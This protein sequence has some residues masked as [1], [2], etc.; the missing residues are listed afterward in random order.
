[1]A[2]GRQVVVAETPSA[3]ERHPIT[4]E[5]LRHA[6]GN[7]GL[8]MMF[9]MAAF[10]NPGHGV[11]LSHGV[12][13]TRISDAVWS[14]GLI[15]MGVF[16]VM[17]P[18]PVAAMLDWRAMLSGFGAFLLPTLMLRS[19]FS[20]SGMA[21]E[22]GVLLEFLGVVLS[23]A[24]RIC[25]GHTFAVL[26]ANRGIVTKGPFHFVRHPVYLGWIMLVIGFCATY[27][28]PWNVMMLVA[29]MGLTFW[30]IHLEEELLGTDPAYVEY[31]SKVP[32]RMIP[33]VY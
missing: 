10:P 16:C 9:F 32:W 28:N 7:I 6:A 31:R 24:S 8:A 33:G 5:G 21:Y 12:H 14:V 2:V 30:R 25:M 1:M 27:P 11:P 22:A 19:N 29:C 3:S 15:M 4:L 18:K 20:A 23:Q 13:L 17:R 26:P